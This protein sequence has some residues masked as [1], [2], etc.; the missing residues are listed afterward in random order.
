MPYEI[1]DSGDL[2]YLAS[3]SNCFE[4]NY[5]QSADIALT[6]LW[7]PIG[8]STNAFVGT[9]DGGGFS[10]SNLSIPAGTDNVGLF[11]Y[12]SG[13][14]LTGINVSSGSVN[15]RDYVGG[16]VGQA[17]NSSITRSSSRASVSGRSYVGG[18]IGS[19][20]A[21]AFSAR[22]VSEAFST[23]SVTATGTYVGGLTGSAY[24]ITILDTYATGSV[25]GGYQVGGLIGEYAESALTRAYA[26]GLV[27]LT[28]TYSGGVV[29]LKAGVTATSGVTWNVD[30]TGQSQWGV[31]DDAA[32]T[33]STTTAMKSIA[34]YR[35][36]D[37]SI[38]SSW[39][40][41]TTWVICPQ[42]NNGYPFLSAFYTAQTAPCINRSGPPPDVMQQVGRAADQTC[43]SAGTAEMNIGG[44]ASGGWGQSWAQWM[45]GG[46]G[47]FICNRTLFYNTAYGRWEVRT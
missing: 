23:G 35:D 31:P 28:N 8:I 13:A 34:T 14:T 42:A 7:T 37:W 20:G 46:T 21:A 24:R 2:A 5:R 4:Y 11:G 29:G 33:G 25:S 22:S 44:V 47:G 38:G 45:N 10:I 40:G 43:A 26:T 32:I 9:Y 18:L 12:I 41:N 39:T 16:L 30:T 27:T 36:L 15:G 3:D 6:T 1:A 19:I 17:P